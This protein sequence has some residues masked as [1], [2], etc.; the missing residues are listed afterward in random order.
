[1]LGPGWAAVA[2]P[3]QPGPRP[4]PRPHLAPAPTWPP[5]RTG[6]DRLKEALQ[7]LGLKCGGTP[8]QRAERLF[9]LKAAPLAALDRKHFVPGASVAKSEADLAK[10]EQVRQG[11]AAAAGG[12]RL[13]PG[14]G[15]WGAGGCA[16][17]AGGL[18]PCSWLLLLLPAPP[19]GTSQPAPASRAPKLIHLPHLPHP[20]TR[21]PQIGKAVALLEARC[22]KLAELL[23]NVVSDT[24][25][26]LEKKQAQTY[27]EMVADQAEAEAEALAEEGDVRPRGGRGCG[28]CALGLRC[29][30]AAR[31]RTPA[32]ADCPRHT[33][34][35]T[36]AAHPPT[37]TPPPPTHPPT[38]HHPPTPGGGGRVHLQP[39][40]AAAGLGRQAHPLLALQAARPQP[41][42]QVRDLRQP[43]LLGAARVREALP[44]GPG[45]AQGRRGMARAVGAWGGWGRGAP[46]AAAR[47]RASCSSQAAGA[48]GS[49]TSRAPRR[50][51]HPHPHHATRPTA[52][53]RRSSSTSRECARWASPCPRHSSR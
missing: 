38:H 53:R 27:E 36:P 12:W 32:P 6:A 41:G 33:P 16:G 49:T 17:G 21:R 40:Q 5:P 51:P 46:A 4:R 50:R 35:H 52:R 28:G 42:V 22:A 3:T 48:P 18:A 23:A 34:A 37:T 26:R 39:A 31:A 47:C 11:A 1:M 14:A 44:G 29:A 8:R 30:C 43:Q 13:G 7:A 20:S 9:L 2:P 10:Q 19:R 24:K 45:G 25:A 15:G